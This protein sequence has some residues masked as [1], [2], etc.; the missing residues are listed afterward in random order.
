M[1][2][3]DMTGLAGDTERETFP[4]LEKAGFP[5][6]DFYEKLRESGLS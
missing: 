4:K 6:L 2:E 5:Q 1:A 3:D